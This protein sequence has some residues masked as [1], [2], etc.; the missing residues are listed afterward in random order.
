MNQDRRMTLTVAV[1]V[2]FTSTV[3]FPPFTGSVWFTAGVG[4]VITVAAA[5]TLSRLRTLP[6]FVCLAISLIALLLYL[7]LAFEASRSYWKFLPTT[8]SLAALGGLVRAGFSDASKYAP[9]VPTNVTGLVF[10]AV[11]GIGIT[12]VFT[13]LIAVRL[14]SSAMAGLPLL[15]LFTVPVTINVQRTAL[16]TAV[17]FFLAT[18]GYL[19]MLSADGRERIRVWGRLISLWR[20]EDGAPKYSGPARANGASTGAGGPV[21]SAANGAANGAGQGQTG[22]R[23]QKVTF[24]VLRGPDTRS[25]A[26][27]GRRVGFASIV[28]ALF[29]PLLVPGLHA[30]RIASADWVFGNSNGTG[31]GTPIPDLLTGVATQ[32]QETHSHVV[33]TYTTTDPHPQYLQQEVLD[34][35]SP[36]SG[37]EPFANSQVVTQPFFTQLPPQPDGITDPG[38]PQVTTTITVANGAASATPGFNFLAVPYPPE[39]IHDLTGTWEVDPSTLTV[40]TENG[41]LNNITYQVVSQDVLPTPAQLRKTSQPSDMT[42]TYMTDMSADLQLP[43]SYKQSAT[44]RRL[45]DSITKGQPTNFDK[46]NA[47]A[48]WLSSQG[49][50]SYNTNA[51]AISDVAG[52]LEYLDKDKI[53]DCVQAAYSMTVL[54]RVLGIPSRFVLG[55]TQGTKVDGHYEVKNTDAHAWPEA[56]FPSYG[57]IRFEPTPSGGQGTAQQPSYSQTGTTSAGGGATPPVLPSSSANPNAPREISGHRVEPLPGDDGNPEHYFTATAIPTKGTTPWAALALAIIAAIAL[58]CGI[59]A[60]VAP[61]GQRALS[62]R[63]G[64]RLRRRRPNLGLVAVVL[65]AGAIVAILLDKMLTHTNGLDVKTGWATVGIAF[66]AAAVVAL[67]V[68]TGCRAVLRWW[69]WLRASDD[70]SRVHAAWL[71]LRADLTDYGV[72][73]LASESPRALAGRVTSGL[74]LAEPAAEAVSRIALAEERAVYAGR[75]SESKTLRKDGSTARQGIAAASGRGARWRARIFP[76]STLSALID[77]ITR[78]PDTWALLRLRWQHRHLSRP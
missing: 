24:Q 55:Y 46:A 42:E 62:A 51:P 4:A 22:R 49:G 14:R 12:A 73:Q 44:L 10:L 43:A 26:A 32:L 61:L 53:G 6:V 15:V 2:V 75:P 69:H 18:A 63:P 20:T 40:V 5:G 13:D 33:M 11:A 58:A 21:T 60:I 25:L 39:S 77:A 65:G 67:T 28:L 76:A 72:A 59:V 7:N 16:T 56:F 66:G 48:K 36:T 31:G 37:W 30:A 41:S 74:A 57:W 68:P 78:I 64:E 9:P 19:A 17:I 54:L 35:L 38:Q 71:E 70:A 34:T 1:A 23:R 52:L 3:L 8:A 27:A 29:A 50:F 47:L 45:A